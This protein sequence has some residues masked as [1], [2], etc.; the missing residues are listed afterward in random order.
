MS[1]RRAEVEQWVAAHDEPYRLALIHAALGNRDRTFEAL[2]SAA[3]IV[4]HRVVP[5]CLYPEMRWLRGDPD[6]R[7]FARSSACLRLR[8]LTTAERAAAGQRSVP[9]AWVQ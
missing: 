2:N 7:C 6:L 3:E 1:G 5:L 4:P 9:P 8:E